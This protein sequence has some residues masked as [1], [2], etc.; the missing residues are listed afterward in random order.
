M[1]SHQVFT[2]SRESMTDEPSL[3]HIHLPLSKSS[4]QTTPR[5]PKLY[6]LARNYSRL[7]LNGSPQ[8][9]TP[10]SNPNH[11]FIPS[12][13]NQQSSYHMSQNQ[14]NPHTRFFYAFLL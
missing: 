2:N 13:S 6:S 5:A 12:S 8:N 7:F 4:Y 11:V 9:A 3:N 14:E 1:L 10:T